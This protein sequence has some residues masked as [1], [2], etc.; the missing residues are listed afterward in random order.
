MLLL[1]LLGPMALTSYDT[2]GSGNISSSPNRK[3]EGSYNRKDVLNDGRK[4]YS[5]V[6]S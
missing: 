1:R 3:E 6:R 5:R 2:K 4:A